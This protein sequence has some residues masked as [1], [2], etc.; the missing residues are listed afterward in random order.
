MEAAEETF[1]WDPGIT[2][3]THKYSLSFKIS[4]SPIPAQPFVLS[5][6]TSSGICQTLSHILNLCT[7]PGAL[8]LSKAQTNSFIDFPNIPLVADT[9]LGPEYIRDSIL[10][11]NLSPLLIKLSLGADFQTRSYISHPPCIRWGHVTISQQ[12]KVSKSDV[13]HSWE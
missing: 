3:H 5:P 7:C 9:E 11:T 8:W 6:G 10:I 2:C 13:Y 4:W 1:H 12:R